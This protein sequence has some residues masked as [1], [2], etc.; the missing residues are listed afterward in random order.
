[1]VLSY[2]FHLESVFAQQPASETIKREITIMRFNGEC[3]G[4]ED[5]ESPF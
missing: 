5:E 2:M 3:G 4:D 1:M